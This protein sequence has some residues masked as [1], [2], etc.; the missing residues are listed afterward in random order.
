[1]QR[2]NVTL[3]TLE[4]KQ[5]GTFHVSPGATVGQ[6]ETRRKRLGP[7][8]RGAAIIAPAT[9]D[10]QAGDAVTAI[11]ATRLG[12]S[13]EAKQRQQSSP[14]RLWTSRRSGDCG[15]STPEKLGLTR[16]RPGDIRP[17]LPSATR[18]TTTKAGPSSDL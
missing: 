13:S 6:G 10:A 1:M 17:L 5:A 2:I 9:G 4:V 11:I 18:F 16:R 15:W 12:M 8:R 3:E 14:M 7:S